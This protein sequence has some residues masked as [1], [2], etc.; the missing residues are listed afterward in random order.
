MQ[1]KIIKCSEKFYWYNNRIGE[2]F[3]VKYIND[4]IFVYYKL[5]DGSEIRIDDT[6][7][8]IIR[9]EKIENILNNINKCK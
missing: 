2:I 1:V 8:V 9:K 7:P 3:D 6:R 5:T 4:T